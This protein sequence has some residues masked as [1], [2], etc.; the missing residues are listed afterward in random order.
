M[1]LVIS[2][3]QAEQRGMF[4]GNKG[5]Q[6]SLHYRLELTEEEHA[7]VDR[8]RLTDHVLT[9]SQAKVDTVRDAIQGITETV[10]SVEILLNNEKAIKRACDSFYRLV[11]VAQSF[12]GEEIFELPLHEN[13]AQD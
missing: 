9:R 6:F 3:G 1:Q 5:V 2:R 8:Y 10:G 12:G 13:Q 4:G 11:L 7:L